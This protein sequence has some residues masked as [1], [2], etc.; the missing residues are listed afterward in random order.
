VPSV[1]I[2]VRRPLDERAG[3]DVIEAVHRA[4]REAFRIPAD[5]R[6]V[7][8]VVHEPH[9]FECP[10]D[11]SHPELYTHVSVDAFSGRSLEAKRALYRSIVENLELLGIPRDHVKVLLREIP[12]ENWG[13]RGGRAGSDV[14]LGFEVEV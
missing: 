10:P 12:R 3:A 1:L 7:R 11:R 13:I 5:D 8:L 14:E 6:C 9:R 2:E 4:L